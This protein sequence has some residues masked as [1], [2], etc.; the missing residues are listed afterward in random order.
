MIELSHIK[1]YGFEE[2]IRGMRNSWDSWDDSDFCPDDIGENNLALMR[3]LAKSGPDHA[4]F[5]RMINVSMDILAPLYW[6]KEFDTYKIGTSANSCSTMHTICKK[7]FATKDFSCE[8]LSGPTIPN[9]IPPYDIFCFTILRLNELRFV[10]LNGL[11]D[12]EGNVLFEPKNKDIWYQII[13]L[14][15]SS[16]NQLRTVTLNYEVLRRIYA[17]RKDHKLD[18]W[19][20]FCEEMTCFP[21]CSL[22]TMKDE[23]TEW[24]HLDP[25][26]VNR[27]IIVN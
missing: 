11:T 6:W 14:L 1:V 19:R 26:G 20:T 16:Y 24:T 15:P 21:V 5:L 3:R 8:K 12:E 23:K 2:A 18:E 13:Q 17:A 27:V 7:E 4:K 25:T 22:I 10:Y 9:V